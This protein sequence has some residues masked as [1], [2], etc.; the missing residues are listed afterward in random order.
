MCVNVLPWCSK[1]PLCPSSCYHLEFWILKNAQITF[2]LDKQG[3]G[4]VFSEG[5]RE[6]VHMKKFLCVSVDCLSGGLT[7]ESGTDF[8]FIESNPWEIQACFVHDD[9]YL[10]K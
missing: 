3:V 7:L 2:V 6:S 9:L 1:R 5:L 4:V 8:Q 10:L